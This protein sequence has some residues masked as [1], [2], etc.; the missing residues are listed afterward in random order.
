MR[1]VHEKAVLSSDPLAGDVVMATRES[2]TSFTRSNDEGWTNFILYVDEDIV[3]I[4]G[5][6]NSISRWGKISLCDFDGEPKLT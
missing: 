5:K 2:R 1:C 3:F 6:F 4:R